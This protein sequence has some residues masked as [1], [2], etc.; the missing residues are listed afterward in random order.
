MAFTAGQVLTA[1]A[2]NAAVA[3]AQNPARCYATASSTQ[4]IPNNTITVL[5]FDG[6]S[7]DP[8]GMHSTVSNTSRIVIPTTGWYR[9]YGQA[10]LAGSATGARNIFIYVNGAP[11]WQDRELSPGTFT[12]VRAIAAETL[13]AAGNYVELGIQ[14][15]SGGALDTAAGSAL[16]VVQASL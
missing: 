5:N 11:V 15:T 6:E 16:H 3:V 14:Q 10:L 2:L 7:Y 8:L 9:I 1:A 13:L 4:S 12:T